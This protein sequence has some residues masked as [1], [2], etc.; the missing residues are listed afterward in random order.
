MKLIDNNIGDSGAKMISEVLKS[1]S[2]LTILDL[3]GDGKRTKEI[4]EIRKK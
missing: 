4:E 3:F 1:N 2:I